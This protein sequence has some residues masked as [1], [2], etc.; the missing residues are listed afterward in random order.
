MTAIVN[1][2]KRAISFLNR[3][4]G[5]LQKRTIRSGIW[6]IF[7]NIGVNSLAFIRSIVLARLLLP[8]IFGLI[9]IAMIVVRGLE[10]FTQTG[11][12]AALIHRQKGFDEAKDTA[13]TLM[14]IRGCLL[15]LITFIASPFIADFYDKSILDAVIKIIAI[16]FIFKGFRNINAISY[17]KGL[18]FKKISYLEQSVAVINTIFVIVF[19]YYFRNVWALVIGNL[20]S[21]FVAALLSYLFIPG[22]PKFEF[23][24]NIAKE[25]FTYGKFVFGLSIIMFV[26]SE[27]DHVLIGKILGIEMLGYYFLAYTLANLVS[28]QLSRLVSR[29]MLPAY[30]LLQ[31][32]LPALNEAFL[33]VFK[34]LSFI[35]IPASA[36][37]IVLAPE[38]MLAVYGEKWLPAAGALQV[39]CVFGAVRA[40]TAL[41]GYLLNGIGKPNVPFYASLCRLFIAVILIYP[42]TK[43]FGLVGAAWSVT[44]AMLTAFIIV[45]YLLTRLIELDALNLLKILTSILFNSMVMSLSVLL[46]KNQFEL[47][48]IYTLIFLVS[49]GMVVYCLLN[50]KYFY[51]ELRNEIF[52]K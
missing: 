27:I 50:F 47:I 36:G 31:N 33:K 41:T 5:S 26:S 29:V 43:M 13:F 1:Q 11:F 20:F 49:I 39:L 30:S 12:A 21:N 17:E 15:F 22:K 23:K 44:T 45:V 51:Y 10:L 28:T 32:D 9:S 25:L 14:V 8:E 34:L 2:L 4:D 38:I 35:A 37:M 48:N 3:E 42:L 40:I 6:V 46:I 24:K 18:N 16:S 19:A 52:R 7:A